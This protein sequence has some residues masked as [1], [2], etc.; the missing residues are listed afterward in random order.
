[1]KDDTRV[2][3]SINTLF[4]KAY[5]PKDAQLLSWDPENMERYWQQCQQFDQYNLDLTDSSGQADKMSQDAFT[6][7]LLKGV[8]L[9]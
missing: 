1:M 7:F 5:I 2:V 8:K 9:K 6:I 4:A 3:E